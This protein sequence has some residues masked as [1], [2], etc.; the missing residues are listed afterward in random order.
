MK[1]ASDI[2]CLFTQKAKLQ[3]MTIVPFLGS[4]GYLGK[5]EPSCSRGKHPLTNSSPNL[6]SFTKSQLDQFIKFK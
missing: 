6:L 2:L 1:V 3:F 4:I 5:S